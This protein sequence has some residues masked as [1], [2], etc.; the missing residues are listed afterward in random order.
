VYRDLLCGRIHGDYATVHNREAFGTNR[1]DERLWGYEG[2]LWLK[3]HKKSDGYYF[4]KIIL[5][6]YRQHGIRICNTS[7]LSHLSQ[8]ILG[9][10]IRL[11]EFGGDLKAICPD[12]Y[13]EHLSSLGYFQMLDGQKDHAR[14]NILLSLKYRFSIKFLFFYVISYFLLKQQL[15]FLCRAFKRV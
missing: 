12:R 15:I 8:L 14:E 10:S 4:P 3:L 6:K 7:V 1:F 13:A 11:K 9:E 2:L 5:K